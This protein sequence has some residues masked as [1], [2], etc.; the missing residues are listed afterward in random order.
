MTQPLPPDQRVGYAVIGVG[1]LTTEELLP[2]FEASKSSRLAALVS[3]DVEDARRLARAYGLRD[4][5]ALSYDD[6]EKL[7]DREDVHA[8][9][10]VTPNSL[11][12]EYTERAARMNKHV[13][14]EKPMATTVEDAEAMIRACD[15]AGVK[16]MIAYRCQYTPQH[17]ALRKLVQDGELGAPRLL[18]STNTQ[19]ETDPGAWRLKMDL[20]GG[21][22]LPDIG[23]YCLNTIRFVLG[24]E[25]LEVL[26]TQVRPEDDERFT[27]VERDFAWIMR[28][29][30]GVTATCST[31]YDASTAR[32]LNVLA[33]KGRAVMDPAYD[34]QGLRLEVETPGERSERKIPEQDQFAL[35]IDHF[36]ECVLRGERPFT[37]GEE[38][39][40]DQRI[41]AALYESARTG[42]PV[43]L[44][45][46]PGRDV[47]RGT[48]PQEGR[49]G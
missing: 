13:L 33:E 3:G 45:A 8:V 40:Q 26:A 12:R 21:G 49:E 24:T 25:P 20:A 18:D 43:K 34:Y 7:G 23:L 11:H 4:E 1:E 14:C 15:G 27:E 19:M 36:S 39:L 17:W 41:M 42:R 16:L 32:Y 37:P 48:V 10:I 6:L 30:D 2:A 44:G 5:D 9:Y 29:P 46:A 35:E 22:P 31:S 38:G 28:F 47:F